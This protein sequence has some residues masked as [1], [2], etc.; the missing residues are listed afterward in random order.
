MAFDFFNSLLS[1][2]LKGTEWLGEVEDNEDPD[3]AG[4]CAPL[5]RKIARSRHARKEANTASKQDIPQ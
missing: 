1:T 2:N 5:I 3:F 4:R